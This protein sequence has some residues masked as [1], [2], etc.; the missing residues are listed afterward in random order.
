[1]NSFEQGNFKGD[2]SLTNIALCITSERVID[3]K[4]VFIMTPH[5]FETPK[6]LEDS[7]M[8]MFP[9]RNRDAYI[10]GMTQDRVVIVQGFEGE[11]WR[12][13]CDDLIDE[14][15]IGFVVK[16]DLREQL[17]DVSPARAAALVA[18]SV[19]GM[20]AYIPEEPLSKRGL[21]AFKAETD[22]YLKWGRTVFIPEDVEADF[23]AYETRSEWFVV[24]QS[25]IQHESG[26]IEIFPT[27]PEP[28]PTGNVA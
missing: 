3:G 20:D 25:Q 15:Q 28:P 18:A 2:Q 22:Q 4:T 14:L 23:A 5:A 26:M 6:T 10:P 13:E 24:Q 9:G 11:N 19:M 1:M 21:D 12:S 7:L 16:M 17:Q 27:A 8:H